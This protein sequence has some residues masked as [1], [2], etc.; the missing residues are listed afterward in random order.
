MSKYLLASLSVLGIFSNMT[1]V[2]VEPC[3]FIGCKHSKAHA[4]E[5]ESS[6]DAVY[7]MGLVRGPSEDCGL[8]LDKNCIDK[9]VSV[10]QQV[11]NVYL[12]NSTKE[13]Y[14]NI[15]YCLLRFKHMYWESRNEVSGAL[16]PSHPREIHHWLRL[17]KR[18]ERI[19]E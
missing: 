19:I 18:V 12:L 4:N 7:L 16:I 15:P 8:W 11:R 6:F 14:R 13:Q 17:R 3:L 2:A 1:A 5:F 10:V 9:K